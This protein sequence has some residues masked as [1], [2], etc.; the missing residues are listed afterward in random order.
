MVRRPLRP[1]E[2]MAPY[3]GSAGEEH[4]PVAEYGKQKLLLVRAGAQGAMSRWQG[5][6]LP[7][8]VV[9]RLTVLAVMEEQKVVAAPTP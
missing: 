9:E 1:P 6:L 2:T 8:R 5:G 4:L 7:R 3:G